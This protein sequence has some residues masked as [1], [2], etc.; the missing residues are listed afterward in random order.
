MCIYMYIHEGSVLLQMGCS[1]NV[2]VRSKLYHIRL[3]CLLNVMCGKNDGCLGRRHELC[4][5]LPDPRYKILHVYTCV[6]TYI[7]R[8]NIQG[9]WW[10]YMYIQEYHAVY[11]MVICDQT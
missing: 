8:H 10:V 2:H 4:Q 6:G 9:Q 5:M 7:V 3:S 1:C 11:Y